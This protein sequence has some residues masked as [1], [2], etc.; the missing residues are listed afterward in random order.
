MFNKA[1]N[2]LIQYLKL[3]NDCDA[4]NPLH[5]L[6]AYNFLWIGINYSLFEI[7]ILYK[8]KKND[9]IL[10]LSRIILINNK[11]KKSK[12]FEIFSP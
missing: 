9:N 3:N 6:S 11:R 12:I 8:W 1:K 7:Y 5:L 10:K 2:T 4:R